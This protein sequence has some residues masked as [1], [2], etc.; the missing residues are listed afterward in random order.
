MY[1]FKDFTSDYN[2]MFLCPLCQ[3][4]VSPNSLID[5]HELVKEKNVTAICFSALKNC[6]G[7]VCIGNCSGVI[8]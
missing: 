6:L 4:T 2:L 7:A 3:R 5:S 1:I 8:V